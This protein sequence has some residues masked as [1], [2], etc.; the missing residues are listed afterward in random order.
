MD[1]LSSYA[2]NNLVQHLVRAG[3][4][5]AVHELFAKDGR[6]GPAWY[7][8]KQGVD[9]DRGYERELG[10]AWELAD[11]LFREA[12]DR[13]ERGRAVALQTRY[14]LISASLDGLA[15]RIAPEE[16]RQHVQRG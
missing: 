12:G 10:L 13:S 5:D 14:A 9:D 15:D 6:A 16:L 1:A 2:V 7:E 8:L 11:T 3:R 4:R